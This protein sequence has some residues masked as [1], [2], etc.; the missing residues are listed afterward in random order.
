VSDQKQTPVCCYCDHALSCAHCGME[1]PADEIERLRAAKTAALKI[2]DERAIEAVE[3]LAWQKARLEQHD[4]ME[5]ELSNLRAKLATARKALEF[6]RDGWVFK[7]RRSKTG[8]DLSSW[9][10]RES[11]MGDYGERARVALTDENGK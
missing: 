8:I 6:Y 11:L 3:L 9:E 2:A 1:Q 10:P 4:Q 5:T 7:P